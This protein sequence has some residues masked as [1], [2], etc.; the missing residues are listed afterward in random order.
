VQYNPLWM[1]ETS[2]IQCSYL[3]PA[4]DFAS[5]SP[6]GGA[7]WFQRYIANRDSK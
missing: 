1:Q 4:P 3:P 2:D 7:S 6:F 5:H